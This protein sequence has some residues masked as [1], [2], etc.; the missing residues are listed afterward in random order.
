MEDITIIDKVANQ[1]NLPNWWVESIAIQYFNPRKITLEKENTLWNLDYSKLDEDELAEAS[2]YKK[3][4][5]SNYKIFHNV[6]KE[7]F[8]KRYV[9]N[10]RLKDTDSLIK[11]YNEITAKGLV[12]KYYIAF[13]EL[14]GYIESPEHILNSYYQVLDNGNI[15]QWRVL[16]SIKYCEE[17]SNFNYLDEIFSLQDKHDYL[18][19]LLINPEE[20]NK[21]ELKD[22]I[23]EYLEWCNVV[24]RSLV[25]TLYDA[26]LAR[27]ANCNKEQYKN[28]NTSNENFPPII[29]SYENFTLSKGIIKSNYNFEGIFY[30]NCCRSLDKSKYLEKVSISDT[31]LTKNIDNIYKEK[32]SS[33]IMGLSCIESYINT[34]GCIYFENIWDETLDFNL[35]SKIRFYIKLI[36]KRT[37]FSE[38]ELI[39][40]NNI[41]GLIKLKEEIFNNDKSFEDSTIDNN[42][43]VSILNKKLSNENLVNI[44]IIIKDFIILIS[45]IG[46]MKLPFWLKIK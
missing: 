10:N 11:E 46:N 23:E 45:S 4:V 7:I 43:I 19:S 26:H 32:I 44:D 28:L 17:T 1:T 35:K 22:K 42:T 39:T 6:R 5:I 38:E 3:A 30:E 36:S 34:V 27:L 9:K 20:V 8:Y 41:Y 40:I 15:Y 16:D 25:K 31:E 18:V 37:D 21:D 12:S 24:K 33:L 29:S 13:K 2:I 14:E